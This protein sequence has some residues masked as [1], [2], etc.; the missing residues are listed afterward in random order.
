MPA[1][2]LN[3]KYHSAYK[4]LH[5]TETGLVCIAN[6]ILH[7]VDEKKV[8]LVL[9]DLSTAFDI[10]DHDVLLDCMF[11]RFGIQD[12]SLSWFRSYLSDRSQAV[13]LMGVRGC[14]TGISIGST[15]VLNILRTYF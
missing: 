6:D 4:Q 14:A 11:K 2:G 3:D 8:V 7:C 12:T 10:A 9:L 1:N 13:R 5:S 15:C